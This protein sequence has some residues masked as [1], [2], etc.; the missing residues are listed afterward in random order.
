MSDNGAVISQIIKDSS[1]AEKNCT[2]TI[3]ATQNQI[4][5]LNTKITAI[6]EGVCDVAAQRLSTY[7]TNTYGDTTSIF[8]TGPEYNKAYDSTGNLTQWR[9]LQVT[10]D[11]T[12][13]SSPHFAVM[14][15]RMFYTEGDTTD[16]LYP[17]LLYSDI[18]FGRKMPSGNIPSKR[19]TRIS[20]A[21][22]DT[23]S[24]ITVVTVTDGVISGSDNLIYTYRFGYNDPT[25]STADTLISQ[26]TFAQDLLIKP[27][28]LDGTYGLI[29]TRDNLSKGTSVMS[30]NKDKNAATPG[31]LDSYKTTG[32]EP[33]A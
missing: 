6:K 20:T 11:N 30:A 26:W 13:I 19:T 17:R 7:I 8:V 9:I 21:V 32:P 22:Y 4:D 12:V 5:A 18:G 28:G 16:T 14:N 31:M 15:D 29:P 2:A 25:D 24:N 10:F 27:M 23:S 1:T 33:P 3:N